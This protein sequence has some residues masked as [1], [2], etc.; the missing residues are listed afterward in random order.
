LE[1]REL[2]SATAIP[3]TVSPNW[4]GDYLLPGEP[5]HVG[6]PA[7]TAQGTTAAAGAAATAGQGN[8]YDW[9]V[10]FDTGSLAG[11]GSA[12]QTAG[13]L[14][15]AAAQF[16]VLLGL[17]REGEVLV[18]SFG[19][20]AQQVAAALRADTHVALYEMDSLKQVASLPNDPS[21][22]Q[23]WSLQN[24]GQSNG[25]AGA[26]INA[27]AAWNVSTGSRNVVVAVI[28]SGV[29]YTHADLAANIW[30]NPYAGSDGFSGDVHGYNF[31]A[32]NGNPM[33]DN[34]H[35]THVAGIIGADG[36]NGAGIAGVAWNVSIM[37]L[38][39]MDAN[40]DGNTSDAIRAINYAVMMRTQY[41]V[42]VRVINA[43][44]SGTAADP[45]LSAAI[46]AAGN[47]GILFVVAAGN[48]GTNNDSAPQYPANFSL[49]NMISVAASDS[50]DHLAAFSDYGA[51][52]VNLAAPGVSI[53]STLPGNTYGYLSGTSMAAPEVSGVAALAWAAAPNDSLAQIRNAILQGVDKL[54]AL[55][56]EVSS[57]GRLDAY[58]T[59]RLLV[60]PQ[61][62]T[63]VIAS[64][65][66]NPGAIASGGTVTL[67]AQGA[68]ESGGAITG[69]YF[70]QDSNGNGQW[71]AADR[72]IG[73]STAVANG[74]AG[75][76][77][78]TAGMAA[79][80][81]R[82]FARALDGNNQWS[83]A[84]AAQLTVTSAVSH[85]TN[86][87]TAQLVAVGNTA[88]GSINAPNDQ[89]FFK[90]QAL[91]GQQYTFQ[92]TLGTLHDSV[93]SLLASDGQ[94]VLA[95]N[96]DISPGNL[97][98]RIN[99]RASAAGTYYL[100]VTTYPGAGTG[101]FTLQLS[102]APSGPPVLAPIAN[103]AGAQ[104]ST[105]VVVLSASDPAGRRV[106]YGAQVLT[107]VPTGAINVV[108]VGNVVMFR[109]APSFTGSFQVLASVSDGVAS[110]SQTFS[111]SIGPAAS[112]QRTQSVAPQQ[113]AATR[114]LAAL[115]DQSA[116]AAA[117]TRAAATPWNNLP[118]TNRPLDP[119]ILAALYAAWGQ[120]ESSLFTNRS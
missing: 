41:N 32:N 55:A 109:P 71:D 119:G 13:L 59:L 89:D 27:T 69:V 79:G 67:S 10:Q 115:A 29:D 20:S 9:I 83:S 64:L 101:S 93:L 91:A 50:T 3:T 74:Q 47:A 58:N 6:L 61:I 98:S 72:L 40:G 110:A 65:T 34:G 94:T 54:P 52:T 87:A 16:Q 26:D 92:T 4:F 116:L 53:L 90:F 22:S 103:Q 36:N 106:T 35:G 111:M 25:A 23:Q 99:W 82:L 38:K 30:T 57:G 112:R 104:G 118:A 86:P 24:T 42:N 56:N 49:S 1:L 96:D 73:S 97:A 14:P 85:G 108:V 70:Y 18:R 8:V 120:R 66:A 62:L 114:G 117:A 76:A 7:L 81:Y 48:N 5:S 78:S 100:D 43:S 46:Q 17:G 44:W 77:M 84:T 63:P 2:L 80:N 31:V 28:D 60:Q 45:A 19:A 75:F 39:F 95:Q 21:F 15:T 11:I 105:L 113:P 37:P 107:A 12:A 102:S 88:N 51:A 33:D 68:S